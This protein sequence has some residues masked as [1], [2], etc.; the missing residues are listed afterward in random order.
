MDKRAECGNFSEMMEVAMIY[1]KGEDDV[2]KNL[3]KAFRL[4]K[5]LAD[6]HYAPAIVKLAN[7]YIE[8]NLV[9][10]NVPYAIELYSKL[11][12]LA[13]L[14]R[15]GRE[16]LFLYKNDVLNNNVLI[17]LLSRDYVPYSSD[18]DEQWNA[19][20]CEAAAVKGNTK[21]MKELVER[22]STGNGVEK[23]E[24]K[25]LTLLRK[26]AEMGDS[27]AMLELGKKLLDNS[28]PE[29]YNVTE[30]IDWYLKSAA[31]GNVNA[32]LELIYFFNNG[33]HVK[34]DKKFAKKL[35]KELETNN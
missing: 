13:V 22:Y 20:T 23:D 21:A 11:Y 19:L 7:I 18:A 10:K 8:G 28:R 14:D 3:S 33:I 34:R 6:K 27:D 30:G 4:Y 2:D 24:T 29:R 1:E 17:E 15:Q 32:K 26:L 5:K 9:Y 31:R 25:S 35:S 16:N 12:D